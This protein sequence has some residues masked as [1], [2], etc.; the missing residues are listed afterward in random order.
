MTARLAHH[1]TG[2][3]HFC[4]LTCKFSGHLS[5]MPRWKNQQKTFRRRRKM[6]YGCFLNSSIIP[7]S[8]VVPNT[9]E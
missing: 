4:S 8:M 1:P 6:G 3:G 2:V 5:I 9:F 7:P